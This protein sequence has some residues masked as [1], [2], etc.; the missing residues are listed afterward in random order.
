MTQSAVIEGVKQFIRA[1]LAAVL[2]L[3]ILGIQSGGIDWQAVGLAGV[4]SILLGID[5]WVHEDPKIKSNGIS[6]I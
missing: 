6:P 1:I 2:P 5:K 4:M 3:I